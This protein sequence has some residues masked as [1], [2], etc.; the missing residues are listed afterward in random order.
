MKSTERHSCPRINKILEESLHPCPPPRCC[1]H[2]LENDESNTCRIFLYAGPAALATSPPTARTPTWLLFS[3]AAGRVDKQYAEQIKPTTQAGGRRSLLLW[4][5]EQ[6]SGLYFLGL[7]LRLRLVL[8]YKNV[9]TFWSVA[10][11]LAEGTN[12]NVC[13][14]CF[15]LHADAPITGEVCVKPLKHLSSNSSLTES[16]FLFPGFPLTL[17]YLTSL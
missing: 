12:S 9:I 7:D 17:W 14:M 2:W 3:A 8:W 15:S 1:R 6:Q 4:S 11:I 5:N 16:N 13:F 10:S